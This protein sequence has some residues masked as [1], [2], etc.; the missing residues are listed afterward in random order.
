MYGQNVP[1]CTMN[2]TGS[3]APFAKN[4]TWWVWSWR[5]E[6]ELSARSSLYKSLR[7]QGTVHQGLPPRY[8]TTYFHWY[9]KCSGLCSAYTIFLVHAGT[10]CLYTQTTELDALSRILCTLGM[11]YR[12][13]NSHRLF[14]C[15]TLY[16]VHV[17]LGSMLMVDFRKCQLVL[18]SIVKAFSGVKTILLMNC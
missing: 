1:A 9:F 16:S 3:G 6:T 2:S 10:F 5:D 14:M 12:A 11:K 13:T 8:S 18:S 15:Q 17:C 4:R 7:Q